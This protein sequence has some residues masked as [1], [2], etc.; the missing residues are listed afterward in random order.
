MNWRR[1]WLST[2]R[3][4][5]KKFFHRWYLAPYL[6]KYSSIFS[7]FLA[8]PS[9]SANVWNPFLVNWLIKSQTIGFLR[10]R[11][12][13]CKTNSPTV[14]IQNLSWIQKKKGNLLLKK[15]GENISSG[16]K[17]LAFRFSFRFDLKKTRIEAF[18][19]PNNLIKHEILQALIIIHLLLFR[20]KA[21]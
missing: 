20:W 18:L 10:R 8:L 17:T 14:V 3:K 4:L 5:H 9:P 15:E 1:S 7:K 16:W 11:I 6:F 12:R 2:S 19:N 21:K 13:P